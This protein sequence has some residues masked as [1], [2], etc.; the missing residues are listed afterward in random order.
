MRAAL[1]QSRLALLLKEAKELQVTSAKQLH[2]NEMELAELGSTVQ[3][4]LTELRA[5]KG[6]ETTADQILEKFRKRMKAD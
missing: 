1:I 6:T 2:K 3:Q 4:L 5:S